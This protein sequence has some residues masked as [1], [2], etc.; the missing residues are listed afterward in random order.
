MKNHFDAMKS[1]FLHFLLSKNVEIEN[2]SSQVL[3]LKKKVSHLEY[4]LDDED[5]SENTPNKP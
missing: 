3:S 4:I 2:L 1:E 5:V